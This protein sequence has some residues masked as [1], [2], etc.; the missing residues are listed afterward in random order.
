MS[1][2]PTLAW[3]GRVI[4]EEMIRSSGKEQYSGVSIAQAF[5]LDREILYKRVIIPALEAGKII[6]Q[7][8]GV[9][10]SFVYQ[11]LQIH[12]PLTDLM[13][14][15]GNKLA[16]KYAPALIIICTAQP[17]AVIPRIEARSDQSKQIFE[18]LSFQRNLIQRYTSEWL[19]TLFSKF[20]STFKFIDTTPPRNEEETRAAARKIWEEFNH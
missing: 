10:T 11:P 17:E 9:I 15:P 8:R 18:E 4:K 1:C 7:E 16:L 3:I 2:E 5:A 6:L 14:L 20:G 12:I 19:Q 13:N